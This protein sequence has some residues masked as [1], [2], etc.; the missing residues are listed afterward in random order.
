MSTETNKR[1]WYDHNSAEN[2]NAFYIKVCAE[3]QAKSDAN[4]F[5]VLQN[6]S[7][8]QPQ[9]QGQTETVPMRPYSTS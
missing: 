9:C 3:A 8:T 5:K 1:G 6:L 2:C 7:K 4:I